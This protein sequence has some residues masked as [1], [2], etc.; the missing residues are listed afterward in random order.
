MCVRVCVLMRDSHN[1]KLNYLTIIA[2]TC[3]LLVYLMKFYSPGPPLQSRQLSAGLLQRLVPFPTPSHVRSLLPAPRT[4][5]RA[6]FVYTRTRG[7]PYVVAMTSTGVSKLQ[8][9]F[10]DSNSDSDSGNSVSCCC[11][12]AESGVS[13]LPQDTEKE[14]QHWGKQ[15]PLI[16]IFAVMRN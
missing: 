8:F 2:C 13:T 9:R 1:Q 15:Y 3:L 12:W 10:C 14:P 11:C 6:T 5:P 16:L 7:F 4:I